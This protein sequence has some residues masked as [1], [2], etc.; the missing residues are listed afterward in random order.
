[1]PVTPVA[2]R[3]AIDVDALCREDPC[4]SV[5]ILG[6]FWPNSRASFES[7]IVKSFKECVP[8][9]SFQPHISQLSDFYAGLVLKSVEGTG[10]D[11]VVRVLG[12]AEREPEANRP[13]SLLADLICKQTGA[14]ELTHLFYRSDSRPAMRLVSHLSGADALK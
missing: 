7:H 10:L 11:W 8:V 2:L 14:R 13:L 6:S 5:H 1:M 3:R 4:D 9:N 12:S